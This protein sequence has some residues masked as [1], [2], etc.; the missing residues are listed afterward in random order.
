MKLLNLARD[1]SELD[2][3]ECDILVA[4]PYALRTIIPSCIS[5]RH[6]AALKF[7]LSID[8]DVIGEYNSKDKGLLLLL[9]FLALFVDDG[10]NPIQCY[11]YS[12]S[13]RIS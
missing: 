13:T 1:S 9:G 5:Y 11:F 12:S 2:I 4:S 6:L 7:F 8:L 10:P 3:D